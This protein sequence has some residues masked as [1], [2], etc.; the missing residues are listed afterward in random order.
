MCCEPIPSRFGRP[1]NSV[2]KQI[3]MNARYQ[4]DKR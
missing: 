4:K 3:D 2:G 1:W